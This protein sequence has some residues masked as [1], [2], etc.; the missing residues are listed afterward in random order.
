M[1]TTTSRAFALALVCFVST[2]CNK[3]CGDKLDFTNDNNYTYSGTVAIPVI[4]TA[5]GVN[6]EICFDQLTNDMQCHKTDPAVDIVNV[7]LTR[8][9]DLTPKEINDKIAN[10]TLTQADTTGYV[11]VTTGGKTCVNTEDMSFL[12]TPLDV[13]SEYYDGA[14]YLLFLSEKTDPGVGSRMV[15]MLAP[16]DS[17]DVTHVDIPNGCGILDF[18]ADL[19]SKDSK[20]VCP[21]TNT[22]VDWSAV[23]T[24]GLGRPFTASAVDQLVLAY[25]PDMTAAELEKNFFDLRLLADEEWTLALIGDEKADLKDAKNA[26]GQNF[27]AFEST[28]IYLFALNLTSNPNPAPK[29]MTVLTTEKE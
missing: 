2:S 4:E 6:I 27:D 1:S 16:S 24:N 25:Y 15:V 5:A 19:T 17:S 13:P 11:D 10:D 7:G 29:F 9:P 3:K 23:D 14:I 20:S 12:G 26:D 18:T 8:V 28:G 22:K 21:D